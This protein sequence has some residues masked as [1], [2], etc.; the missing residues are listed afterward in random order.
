MRR[1]DPTPAKIPS[2]FPPA[3]SWPRDETALL[4]ETDVPLAL[5]LWQRVRDVRL[6][7]MAP[8]GGRLGLFVGRGEVES[9]LEAGEGLA[10][11]LTAPLRALGALV[12]YPEYVSGADLCAACLAVS[13]WAEREHMAETALHFAEAAALADPMS[14]RAAAL[15]GSAC[16]AQAADQRAELWLTRAIRT[17]RR[18]GDWE[19]HARAYLRLGM[20]FYELGDVRRARRAHNRARSSARWSGY[21]TYAAT[22]HHNLLLIECSAG[23]Y[24]AGERHALRALELYSAQHARLPH[25]AHDVG[26]LL[27]L[28]G[29]Y[30]DALAVLDA[31]L[32]F[33]TRPWERVAMMGTVALAAA[34]TGHRERHAGAVADLLLLGPAAETHA[35]GALSLAA[36]GAAMLGDRERARGLAT[37]AL[38]LAERRRE[39]EP[40]RRARRV[41]E[42]AQDGRSAPP[43]AARVAAL[44]AVFVNR[45]HDLRAPSAEAATHV[46]VRQFTMSGRT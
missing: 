17:A 41:L 1:P 6:W 10:D 11:C 3:P 21:Y 34:G 42:G 26:C 35:A 32:P 27:A 36:E 25:L 30:T 24:E 46:D 39:R 18:T 45:L 40:S 28:H 13:E 2:I 4:T 9:T 8:P 31:A 19:W 5:L 20:L 7:A 43:P 38:E 37:R 16:T 14:A 22:A 15:A 29:A 44:R 33:F 12:R 23:T